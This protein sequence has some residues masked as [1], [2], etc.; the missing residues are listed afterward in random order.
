MFFPWSRSPSVFDYSHISVDDD[1]TDR[2]DEEITSALERGVFSE[3]LT[4][5]RHQGSYS[6]FFGVKKRGSDKIRPILDLSKVNMC[7]Q[8]IDFKLESLA[9]ALELINQGEWFTKI[10]LKDAFNH[11][12]MKD[13][14]KPFTRFT[15]RDFHFQWE[16]MGFGIKTAPYNFTKVMKEPIGFLRNKGIRLIVYLDD[17]LI[18]ASSHQESI[19]HTTEIINLLISLGF[20]INWVKSSLEPS[21]VIEFLGWELHSQSLLV[22]LP[23]ALVSNIVDRLSRFIKKSEC[24]VRLFASELGILQAWMKAVHFGRLHTRACGHWKDYWV[25]KVGWDG[26]MPLNDDILDDLLWW[27]DHVS[28]HNG[29]SFEEILGTRKASRVINTDASPSGWGAIVDGITYAGKFTYTESQES[30]N[31]REAMAVLKA[32]RAVKKLSSEREVWEILTDNQSVLWLIN[33]SGGKPTQVETVVESFL[34]EAEQ[35]NIVLQ[36]SFVPG[37]ENL[38]DAPSRRPLDRSD[39]R[40]NLSVSKLIMEKWFV[41]DIDLFATRVNKQVDKFL[42]WFPDQEA[43]G[44]DA[45]KVTWVWPRMWANPPFKLVGRVLHKLLECSPQALL[46]LIAPEWKTAP[47]WPLLLSLHQD[48]I[49]LGS[50]TNLFEPQSGN[51]AAIGE[52]NWNTS[53]WLLQGRGSQ[54][55]DPPPESLIQ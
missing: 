20:M 9:N 19:D 39:W 47:W 32:L 12:K 43:E 1:I 38:A 13:E 26:R 27:R 14:D 28:S 8:S 24:S 55:S 22:R 21:Q 33:K 29:R 35:R 51:P 10:D 11:L 31:V 45:L 3:V 40:L 25:S 6:R 17:I 42:S 52:P 46:I 5:D 30:Q 49:P 37:V 16:R 18:I 15:W 41:P 50:S 34:R 7:I 48:R 36:A 54:S 44:T 53:A 2:L 4:K 23:D